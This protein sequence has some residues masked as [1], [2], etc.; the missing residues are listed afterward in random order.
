MARKAQLGTKPCCVLSDSIVFE[1]RRALVY[2]TQSIIPDDPSR[3][4][5]KHIYGFY[6]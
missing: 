5:P 3:H 6:R 4:H 2:R 1:T